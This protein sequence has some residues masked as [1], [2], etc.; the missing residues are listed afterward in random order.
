MACQRQCQTGSDTG[1]PQPQVGHPPPAGRN[2]RAP[3]EVH[4]EA[5]LHYKRVEVAE[6]LHHGAPAAQYDI[7]EALPD[8]GLRQ[9]AV[10]FFLAQLPCLSPVIAGHA[11]PDRDPL[12][13]FHLNEKYPK[14]APQVVC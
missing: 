3:G 12:L 6:E 1:A 9:G 10:K 7:A 13:M 11:L 14:G 4:A 5:Q 2:W 8:N